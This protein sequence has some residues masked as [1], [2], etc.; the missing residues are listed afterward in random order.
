M[1]FRV[2]ALL[3]FFSH[4][5]LAA[6]VTIELLPAPG[7][8]FIAID[9]NQEPLAEEPEFT[10][11][12]REV[13]PGEGDDAPEGFEPAPFEGEIPTLKAIQYRVEPPYPA[14]INLVE[15]DR[16]ETDTHHG[17]GN[18]QFLTAYFS[19]FNSYQQEIVDIGDGKLY[20]L[21]NENQLH[22][23]ILDFDNE[24]VTHF[25]FPEITRGVNSFLVWKQ[26]WVEEDDAYVTVLSPSVI[27]NRGFYYHWS[28]TSPVGQEGFYGS[29]R[30]ATMGA[31]K[32][33]LG[34][35]QGVSGLAP[36][37]LVTS[38]PQIDRYK[39]GDT[40]GEFLSFDT[41][42]SEGVWHRGYYDETTGSYGKYVSPVKLSNSKVLDSHLGRVQFY[43][44]ED[45]TVVFRFLQLNEALIKYTSA[46]EILDVDSLYTIN[47]TLFRLY[48]E[49]GLDLFS[50]YDLNTN[51][52]STLD[53]P[54]G[55]ESIT[56]CDASSDRIFCVMKIAETYKLYELIANEFVEDRTLEHTW[57]EDGLLSIEGI[58]AYDE[59][60]FVVIRTVN[61]AFN[62]FN[63][64][65]SGS[66]HVKRLNSYSASMKTQ[67]L[68]SSEEDVFFWISSTHSAVFAHK[69]KAVIPPEPEPEPVII[70]PLPE[71][72]PDPEP[73][74]EPEPEPIVVEVPVEDDSEEEVVVYDESQERSQERSSSSDEA[75]DDGE[76]EKLAMASSL[77]FYLILISLLIL[78]T[79]RRINK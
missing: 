43:L 11:P 18:I 12:A 63:F 24:L 3:I 38:E 59:N 60:R 8:C 6:G 58:Y 61:H 76:Q 35:K 56:A 19:T 23:Y 20:V 10:R 53:L 34:V 14:P 29:W 17:T 64:T 74:T 32:N 45:G 79:S 36:I 67:F 52:I 78:S 71:L 2:L 48:T 46:T 75:E 9:C 28:F 77:N 54:L 26:S 44:Q 55:V 22:A 72:E 33:P 7:G 41:G 65:N 68:E 13:L 62:L 47:G 4:D 37:N 1:L 39:R 31:V 25:P 21:T 16:S 30:L 15:L 69:I 40:P 66:Y 42:T 73:D 57:L 49:E 5:V 51:E 70:I 50:W 27:D